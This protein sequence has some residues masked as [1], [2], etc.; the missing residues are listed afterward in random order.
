MNN[1][2]YINWITNRISRNIVFWL[3]YTL[4]HFVGRDNIAQLYVPMFFLIVIAYGIPAYINT[5]LLIPRLLYKGRYLYYT[6]S[7]IVLLLINALISVYASA[8]F[9]SLYPDANFMGSKP[10][11]YW[12]HIFPCFWTILTLTFGK[13]MA[14]AVNHKNKLEEL[15]HQKLHSELESLKSQVNPHFLF[16]ALN[17]IYGMARRT[18]METADAV[19]KL[20][21]ILRYVLYDCSG[22]TIKLEKEIEHLNQYINFARLRTHHKENIQ[23]TITGTPGEHTI[24]PL[25]L[26]PFVENAIKHGLEKQSKNTWVTVDINMK[27]DGLSFRC[28]NSN[29]INSYN[30][31][32]DHGGIGLKNVKRRLEL[33]YPDKYELDIINNNRQYLVELN[34]E[35]S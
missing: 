12:Y 31:N 4:W 19:M 29:F 3:L 13:Y 17:T 35:L 28:A 24:A 11:S 22:H 15:Q 10:Q 33:L 20:S 16:N 18:D 27:R 1:Y 2:R 6:L 5:L 30:S 34:L 21:N 25:L 32:P 26:L 8:F 14:D 9:N 23:L 7:A